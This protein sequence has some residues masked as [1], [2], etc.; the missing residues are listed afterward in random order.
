[1]FQCLTD[2]I[3][4]NLAGLISSPIDLDKLSYLVLDSNASG[5]PYGKGLDIDRFLDGL[6]F[7]NEQK[8]GKA[9]KVVGIDSH[10]IAAAEAIIISRYW[11]ISSIYWH[12]TNRALMAMFSFVMKLVISGQSSISFTD[13][14]E[15]VTG[16]S[17]R[18]SLIDVDESSG[19]NFLVEKF[20]S[21]YGRNSQYF[22]PLTGI[23]GGKRE[24]YKRIVSRPFRVTGK[25]EEDNV[26][27]Q[28]YKDL[29]PS[30]TSDLREIIE[31]DIQ[32]ENKNIQELITHD[33]EN[34]KRLKEGIVLLDVPMSDRDR[35]RSKYVVVFSN[36]RKNSAY[37]NEV[38][39]LMNNI[40]SEMLTNAKK[41][42][43]FVHPK[44]ESHLKTN[45]KLDGVIS[46][47]SEYL[48]EKLEP[49]NLR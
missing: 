41:I 12:H 37:F 14:F 35:V 39:P 18:K 49:V 1:M 2:P 7:V 19:L 6:V 46:K 28:P 23:V 29:L 21:M 40:Q 27:A 9:K 30:I 47:I 22:N 34:K 15:A 4:R 42:R 20:N 26:L 45:S 8:D 38:S 31:S 5:V 48:E 43:V 17:K 10:A 13:F 11:N 44:L 36:G 3:L 25:D 24:I 16:P 32:W 33:G